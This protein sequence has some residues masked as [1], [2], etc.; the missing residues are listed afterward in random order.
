M[1]IMPCGELLKATVSQ[2]EL[3]SWSRT[4]LVAGLAAMLEHSVL[5]L[6]VFYIAANAVASFY[7]CRC[8]FLSSV[9]SKLVLCAEFEQSVMEII[10]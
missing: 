5:P 2:C 10:I 1:H 4:C 7:P 6:T 8:N 3:P 9:T